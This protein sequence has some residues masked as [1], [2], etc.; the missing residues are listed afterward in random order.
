MKQRRL[1]SIRRDE[2]DDA[3]IMGFLLSHSKELV[4]IQYIADFR[5]D[6]LMVLRKQD[7]TYLE[8]DKTAQFQYQILRA[9]GV[10]DAIDF[11]VNF[12][13]TN[14][15]TV[16]SGMANEYSI[17]SVEEEGVD[18]YLFMIGKL[19]TLNSQSVTMH[20]FTGSA[21]WLDDY[22]EIDFADITCFRV[23]DHYGNAYL[24][25]FENVAAENK[26]LIDFD[27]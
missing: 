27:H 18:D 25:Y 10:I 20:E 14:W 16:F 2:L 24:Q 15:H 1:V 6:G 12:A 17:C 19:V 22:T 4:L 5:T 9:N 13:V 11:S 8:C 26:N 7:I 21:R 23:D 3:Q